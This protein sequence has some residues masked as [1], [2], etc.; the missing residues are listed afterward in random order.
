MSITN[1]SNSGN[2]KKSSGIITVSN[3]NSTY[4]FSQ[5]QMTLLV[6]TFYI[7]LA[8]LAHNPACQASDVGECDDIFGGYLKCHSTFILGYC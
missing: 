5:A 3:A 7:P 4:M 1:T 6:T 8:V 2:F